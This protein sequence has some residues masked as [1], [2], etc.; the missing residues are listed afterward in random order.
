MVD[1]QCE[2]I[3]KAGLIV[4]RTPARLILREIETDRLRL[5][6]IPFHSF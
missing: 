5:N 4:Q 2:K 3:S 6:E 1:T